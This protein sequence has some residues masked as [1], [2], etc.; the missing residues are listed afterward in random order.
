MRTAKLALLGLLIVGAWWAMR[1]TASY[2]R[3]EAMIRQH[4]VVADEVGEV[5]S[6]RLPLFGYGVDV[7][8]GRMD[9]DFRVLVAGRK[10]EASVRADFVDGAI[11]DAT[12]TTAEGHTIPLVVPR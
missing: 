3:L 11:V 5:S 8:D 6:I 12:L 4:P 9:P 10:G 2:A 1:Q 7:T